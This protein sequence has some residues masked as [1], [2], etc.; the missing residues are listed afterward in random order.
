MAAR[1]LAEA[2]AALDRL[3][4]LC[5]TSQER[6]RDILAYLSRSPEVVTG[7]EG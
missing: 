1:V 5:A 4:T 7:H 6:E 3:F 2:P